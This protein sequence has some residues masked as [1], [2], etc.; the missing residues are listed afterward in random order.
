MN[1]RLTRAVM[2]H[3]KYEMMRGQSYNPNEVVVNSVYGLEGRYRGGKEEKPRKEL[4]P[5]MPWSCVQ[6]GN[7]H[8]GYTLAC[9]YVCSVTFIICHSKFLSK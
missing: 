8:E 3:F 7:M 9:L 2:K 5:K 1:A 6:F 4:A